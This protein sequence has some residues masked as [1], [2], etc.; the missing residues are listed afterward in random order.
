MKTVAIKEIVL[1]GIG[2][3]I[4]LALY[5]DSANA[6]AVAGAGSSS[7]S[8]SV[9]NNQSSSG[10]SSGSGA[11]VSIGGSTEV[12]LPPVTYYDPRAR[13]PEPDNAGKVWTQRSPCPGNY[14]QAVVNPFAGYGN[15]IYECSGH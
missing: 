11:N 3:V 7:T 13:G 15:M 10:A 2:C 4:G 5:V 6:F 12:H 9:N 8:S 14:S 1:V